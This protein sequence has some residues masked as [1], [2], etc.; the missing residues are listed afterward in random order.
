ME[1][2][3]HEEGREEGRIE[4]G[5]VR[6][7]LISNSKSHARCVGRRRSPAAR[8]GVAAIEAVEEE[9]STPIP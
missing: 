6:S 9:A 7:Q 1:T 3:T 2:D 8:R 4:K 5:G